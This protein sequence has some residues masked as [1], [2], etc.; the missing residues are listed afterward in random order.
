MPCAVQSEFLRNKT[1][2]VI[3]RAPIKML[4]YRKQK[5]VHT[6]KMISITEDGGL[7]QSEPMTAQDLSAMLLTGI[8]NSF[9]YFVNKQ[10]S[11]EE[12]KACAEELYDMFNL[13]ASALLERL[14]PDKEL[15]PDLTAEAIMRAENEI[16]DEA[17]P[18]DDGSEVAGQKVSKFPEQSE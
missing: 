1:H 10:E 14:I 5:E 12:K 2:T 16:L 9:T 18:D 11:E 3:D 13:Q 4:Y 17:V 6:M 15:R 7:M 8:L